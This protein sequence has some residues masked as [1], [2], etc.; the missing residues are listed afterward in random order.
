MPKKNIERMLHTTHIRRGDNDRRRMD[1]ITSGIPGVF[2]GK[3]LFIDATCVS[4][5]SGQ[6]L[7]HSGAAAHDGKCA[8]RADRRTRNT[9]YPDVERSN[10]VQLLSLSSE[11]FGRW[12][13][14]AEDR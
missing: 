4:P 1:L 14:I 13:K 9:D 6:G 12:V 11:I 10:D 2:R 8:E 5:L 3:P 7:P